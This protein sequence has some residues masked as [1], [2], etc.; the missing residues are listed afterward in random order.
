MLGSFLFYQE[1]SA[2]G[3]D[4]EV[5]IAVPNANPAIYT[6]VPVTVTAK[7]T[8][9][10]A[11]QGIQIRV[12]VCG[13][14]AFSF[15]QQNQLVWANTGSSA[16]G[17]WDWLNQRWTIATLAPG[18]TAT[19]NFT[20]FTL[21]TSARSI[22]VFTQASTPDIDSSPGNL[23][24]S[25][26][27]WVCT[28]NEDDE[29]VLTLNGGVAPCSISASVTN[30]QCHD[31]GTPSNPADDKFSFTLTA[32]NPAPSTGYHLFI[33]QTSQAFNGTYGSPMTIQNIAISTGNLT[34]NLTD[35][36]TGGCSATA[37]VTP[38]APC[39][40]TGLPDLSG[41][42]HEV[43]PG[44]VCFTA[45]GQ[46]FGFISMQINNMGTVA[47]TAFKVKFYFSTD[48]QLSANDVLWSTETVPSLGLFN[49]TG[50]A[51]VSPSQVVP[52]S[53]PMGQYYVIVTIDGDNQVVE[54]NEANNTITPFTTQI[55]A[56]DVTLQGY[57]GVP[58]SAM[59]GSSFTAQVTVKYVSNG[60]TF[61][62]GTSFPVEVQVTDVSPYLAVGSV[63]FA[64]SDFTSTS[65]VTKSVQVNVP[66]SLA[67]G[68][69]NLRFFANPSFC[70][71]KNAANWK[72]QSINVTPSGGNNIDLE[73]SLAQNTANPAIYSHYTTTATL[74]N[75]GPQTAT[76]VKVKWMKPTGVVYTGGN[77]YVASQ[78]SFNPNGDQVWTVG[79]I[80]ANGSAT[81]T[82]SYFLLQNGSPVTY[83]Q[84]TAADQTDVD[85]Q[86]NNGT[87]PTPIQDDEAAT[88]GSAPPVLTPDL[89]LSNLEITNSPIQPGQI[90]GYYFDLAN[91]GNGNAP[92]DFVVRAWISTSPTFN[93][94]GIQDGI[95]PTG[96]FNAG[97]SVSEV[98]GASTL[99]T[100][101]APGQY[102]L[103]LWVDA[104]Q[105][106][107][108][109]NENNN[110]VSKGFLIV[111][112]AQS[113]S[114][115]ELMGT[116][117]LTCVAPTANGNLNIYFGE[118][119]SYKVSALDGN[120]HLLSTLPSG[121]PT[122]YPTYR[123]QAGNLEKLLGTTVVYSLPIPA[124]ISGAYSYIL[125]FTELSGGYVML[126]FKT[127]TRDL[128]AVRTDASLNVQQTALL[129]VE[130][131]YGVPNI[132]SIT[133]VSSN[134][135]AFM[136]NN[137]QPGLVASNLYVLNSNLQVLSS[138]AYPLGVLYGSA[139]ISQN[140]CGKFIVSTAYVNYQHRG[141]WFG[142]TIREGHFYNGQFIKEHVY[143]TSEQTS[144]G[145]GSRSYSWELSHP[146]GS[147]IRGYNSQPISHLGAPVDNIVYLV[148]KQGSTVVWEK[149]FKVSSAANI[150][151]IALSGN[152]LVF[153]S[154]VNNAVFVET[155]SCLEGPPPPT[156]CAAINITSAT[157]SLT[158]AGATAPHVLIKLFNPNWTLAFQ[159]LDNCANPLTINNLNAGAYHLQIK[160]IDN[161]WGEIC[162]LEQ[163]VSVSSFGAG[164]GT[165][166]ARSDDR[167]RL[168]LD[169]FYPSPTSYQVT[170]D[171]F[172]PVEQAATLD[173]YDQLGRP[174]HSMKVQLEKGNNPVQ[175]LV[176]DWKSGAYNVI[177]RGE[178]TGLPAYGRFLKVWEE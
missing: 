51:F 86:P 119:N 147:T 24:A 45:P 73:L 126:G 158:I 74:L 91:I 128:F 137:Y 82:V 145:D 7:N 39:S 25:N 156:G 133:P 70:E 151:R 56:A 62:A 81:L 13:T 154:V 1:A 10:D 12:G 134:E 131:G 32:T 113:G 165:G 163:D 26:G 166:I 71:P 118:N 36:V 18:Q 152:E 125:N 21:T 109:S 130:P 168:V 120:G 61:P 75:K 35:N 8:G 27:L 84:V 124:A 4:L 14:N 5:S 11:G 148:K 52:A 19:L 106:V 38:P 98:P 123:V 89:K 30:I 161:G 28:D 72:D 93:T 16:T 94:T 162:Y 15:V 20:L 67:L 95:V 139:S 59:A 100:N 104:D 111:P 143:E 135:F 155:L 77:E 103:H 85:S 159:C 170:V 50:P 127:A 49:S 55:G 92:G 80:P 121:P 33:P 117:N 44:N 138:E 58:A 47:A 23:P 177:A 108:E 116:G 102:Y 46:Q 60:F 3:F 174:V 122:V 146:D 96:N 142:Q 43:I 141:S 69:H 164:G 64:L 175:V 172:S 53:L 178:E 29:A 83:A 54:S 63:N 9:T 66:A 150:R 105:Q 169:R 149:Y 97:F 41:F 101:L 65:T 157:N 160:L 144:M 6:N 31:N 37:S 132:S 90:L 140:S 42:V 17:S 99:P 129:W 153:V 167:Q 68:T 110:T 2:N 40:S 22:Q 88:G 171:V 87:P 57:A 78:G 107:A 114:C 48:N 34:L 76:G 173:F 115:Y 136:A 176:F 112:S 79:S